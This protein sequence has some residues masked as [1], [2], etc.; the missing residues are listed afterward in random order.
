METIISS[1]VKSIYKM[2][3]FKRSFII[4]LT[5]QA[6]L[7]LTFGI[8][9][10]FNPD[11]WNTVSEAAYTIASLNNSIFRS[12]LA[13]VGNNLILF[14][15]IIIGNVFVR[16]GV[17][18]PGLLILLIQGIIIGYVAGS[19]SFEFPFASVAEANFQYLKV[20]LWETTAYALICAVTMT[21]TL[22]IADS[23]PAKQW[24]A[25]RKL[26]EINFSIAERIIVLISV[27]LLITAG[28]IEAIDIASI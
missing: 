1:N 26:R 24:T 7:F 15:L 17:I 13:I 18:T 3:V 22:H 11:A 20:G 27:L 4:W 8:A 5:F 19:N 6:I 9:F 28:Y 2:D 10:Y 12:F 16:F 25:V 14:S 23:F 21:K